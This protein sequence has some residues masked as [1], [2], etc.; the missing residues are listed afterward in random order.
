MRRSS[1]REV[2]GWAVDG[3]VGFLVWGLEV[4][5]CRRG[6]LP[7]RVRGRLRAPCDGDGG[8]DVES[9]RIPLPRR[10]GRAMLKRGLGARVGCAPSS[11]PA[12]PPFFVGPG[13]VSS[14]CQSARCHLIRL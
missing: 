5:R 3:R 6:S 7:G 12:S 1:T 14:R 2:N 4:G 8:A 11:P 9:R 10:A 13:T